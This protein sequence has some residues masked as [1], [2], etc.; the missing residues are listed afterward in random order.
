MKMSPRNSACQLT[1]ILG[2]WIVERTI[3]DRQNSCRLS[4]L[5]EATIETDWFKEQGQTRYGAAR[6][7]SRRS[8][9]LSFSP[10]AVVVSFPD[11]RDFVRLTADAKQHLFH[12]CGHD[13]YSGRVVF[14][15]HDH[16]T[17]MW[18][19]KGPQK[20]YLSFSR[21]RRVPVAGIPRS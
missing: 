5:G 11:A 16:W 12:R 18:R 4:F 9:R 17:E 14:R 3:L 13:V 8:Y 7:R 20:H 21:Y 6:M 15:D 19:V 2:N 1:N 10:E